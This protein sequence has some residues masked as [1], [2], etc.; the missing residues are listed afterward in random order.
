MRT[1]KFL[2]HSGQ[3]HLDEVLAIAGIIIAKGLSLDSVQVTRTFDTKEA[4]EGYDY[5]VDFGG[6]FNGYSHFDHHQG[7]LDVEGKSAFGLVVDSMEEL[8]GLR[9]GA[10]VQRVNYQDNNGP[11]ATIAKLL[12]SDANLSTWFGSFELLEQMMLS[13]FT[14]G[15]IQFTLKMATKVIEGELA[16]ADAKAEAEA[17]ILMSEIIEIEG[18]K[19]LLLDFDLVSNPSYFVIGNAVSAKYCSGNDIDLILGK[20]RNPNQFSLVRTSVGL[21]HG[22]DLHVLKEKVDYAHPGGFI[23]AVSRKADWMKLIT[24]L[25]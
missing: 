4:S 5:V 14:G 3:A 18:L 17:K 10:L 23:A 21:D 2:T 19:I 12:N 11:K 16:K 25:V 7:G 15:D 1:V 20:G 22:L 8:S 13:E 6:N 9:S 24:E